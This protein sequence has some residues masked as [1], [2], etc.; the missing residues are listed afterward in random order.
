MI[1]YY[2]GRT[3]QLAGLI[4]TGE[5]LIM[6]FGEMMPL[7]RGSLLGVTVFYLG[8]YLIRKNHG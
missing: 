3:L 2:I 5:T 1:R 7:L 4:I 8:Y 6:S